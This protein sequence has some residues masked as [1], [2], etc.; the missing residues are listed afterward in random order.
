MPQAGNLGRFQYTGQP[1]VPELGLYLYRNRMYAPTL[2]RFLQTDP[3][4]YADGM[5][6]YAYAGN[7]PVNATD[8][9]G[10]AHERTCTGR[11]LCG[12]EGSSA[13]G[14]SEFGAG[15]ADHLRE[16]GGDGGILLLPGDILVQPIRN[17]SNLPSLGAQ[18]H[19]GSGYTDYD[20]LQDQETQLGD[21]VVVAQRSTILSTLLQRNGVYIGQKQRG[22]SPEV[23]TVNPQQFDA[24]LRRLI[25]S[26]AKRIDNG[27]Y[28]GELYILPD[29]GRLGTLFSPENGLTLDVNDRNLPKG[30]KLHQTDIFGNDF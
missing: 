28:R 24:I 14:S 10:L 30:F 3:T 27:R 26:G 15:Q 5:N 13:V 23:R 9:T 21:I 4:G 20:S 8:P 17:V 29:G 18:V 22:A 2:G 12:Y 7:D 16:G 1:W 6:P 25:R 11:I 19:S